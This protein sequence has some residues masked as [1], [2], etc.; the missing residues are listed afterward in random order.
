MVLGNKIVPFVLENEIAAS[1]TPEMWHELICAIIYFDFFFRLGKVNAL[2]NIL[3]YDGMLHKIEPW[4]RGYGKYMVN[5]NELLI[6][7]FFFQ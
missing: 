1:G 5:I 3:G 4:T 6:C 2:Q 7:Q